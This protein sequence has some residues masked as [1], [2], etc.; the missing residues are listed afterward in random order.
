MSKP[1]VQELREL[2]DQSFSVKWADHLESLNRELG[3]TGPYELSIPARGCP[4]SWFVG[5]VEA[6]EPGRWVLVIAPNQKEHDAG[7]GFTPQTLWDHWRWLHRNGLYDFYRGFVR[8]ASRA[9]GVRAPREHES[10]FATTRMVFVEMCPYASNRSPFSGKD[11][12]R[13]TERDR[14]FQTARRV[15]RT[16]IDEAGPALVLLNA[17]PVVEAVEHLD[18]DRLRLAER[19]YYQ[20]VRKPTKSLWHREGQIIT[21][22]SSV[23]VLGFPFLRTRSAHNAYDEID[24]LGDYAR[25]LVSRSTHQS[26]L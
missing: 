16:L 12:I 6:L 19:H 21:R 3:L 13:L 2:H 7:R 1:W 25:E 18:R 22:G 17:V 5:D 10:D 20:S 4:P 23:P 11:L 8:L 24:Q 15:R 14:G 9:L 26:G